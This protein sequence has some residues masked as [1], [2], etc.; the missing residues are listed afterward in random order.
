MNIISEIDKWM[1]LRNSL[2]GQVGFVPTM[3]ALHSGHAE[4]IKRSLQENDFCVVSIFVNPTQFNDSADFKNYPESHSNDI[5]LCEEL[6]VH[7]V[8]LP[9]Y[10]LLYVDSYRYRINEYDFSKELCGSHREDHF[11][12][13]LT[14]VMKLLNLVRPHR[15]Y[16]GEKDYQ[17]YLLVKDMCAAF[18]MDVSIIACPTVRDRDG[19]AKSSRN[20][21]LDHKSRQ[22]AAHIYETI[23]SPSTDI[24]V[25]STL[26]NLGMEVDYVVTKDKRRFVA[27]TVK[28]GDSHVRL[29]DNTPINKTLKSA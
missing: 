21:L 29:I 25:Q 22:V 28:S 16:F 27:V 3:G 24:E 9:S 18:F 12:G 17:Q 8:L 20:R 4:L 2:K 14:V 13:V 7:V 6:G 11:T 10:D 5:E 23:A 19:L 26:E 15:A 1:S